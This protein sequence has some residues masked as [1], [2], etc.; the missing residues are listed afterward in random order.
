[1]PMIAH[2]QIA[3]VPARNEP[4][5]GEI[6]WRLRV[7]PDRRARLPAAGSAASIVPAGD[8][9]AGLEWRKRFRV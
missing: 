5:T 4:G 6:G 3:D 1:M 9:V 2:M 7:P 8:T